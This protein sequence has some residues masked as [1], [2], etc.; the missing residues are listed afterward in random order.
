MISLSIIISVSFLSGFALARRSE[1]V[2]LKMHIKDLPEDNLRLIGPADP[3]FEQRL[4][5]E[6][7]D[8]PNEVVNTLKPFSV[9][10]ENKGRSTVVA[11]LIQWCFTKPDGSNQYYRKAVMNPQAL[12]D[13]ENLSP[14][15][16]RKSGRIEPDSAI[17]LSL[18][19]TDGGG[20]LRTE[21]TATEAGQ[22]KQ[23]KRFDQS[24]L[25]QRFSAQVSK[26]SEI[27][28]SIDAAFFEDGTFVGP[29]TTSFFNQTKAV[30]DAKRDFLNE[31]AAGLSNPGNARDSIYR[32]VQQTA[33]QT[34]EPI[35]SSSTP[36]DYYNYFKKLSASEFLQ[37]K[38]IQGEDKAI[39]MALRPINKPWTRLRKKTG[40]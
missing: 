8:E 20:I 7:K 40:E 19:S 28:I 13:G 2:S 31:L 25:L 1:M 14:E 18:L 6:L 39:A 30:I 3:S 11:Y 26:F 29:D 33:S 16:R 10:L 24:S 17:F 23:G 4:N 21:A 27:T 37:S 34:V 35:D 9:F 15:L 32:H 5:K 38:D 36:T 12:M 22:L